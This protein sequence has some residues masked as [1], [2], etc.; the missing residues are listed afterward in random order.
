[1]NDQVQIKISAASA[2]QRFNGCDPAFIRDVCHARCCDAPSRPT[3]TLI[4]IHPSEE[5]RIRARDVVVQSG[6]LQ[7]RSGERICPFKNAD[8]LCTL[9][10]TP[11]KPFG[12]IASP[13]TLNKNDTLIIRN[14][15]RL[16]PCYNTGPRL[17]AYR[18]FSASLALILGRDGARAL[19]D[20]L[21]SGGGDILVSIP[22]RIHEMLKTNDAIK[23]RALD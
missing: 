22:A 9:H 3:G 2:R 12:C 6:L 8:H 5:S 19:T 21:D 17:P 18:A 10:Y 1:M 14:R 23:H 4:T 11:D 7:P 13:F 20:H 16:L 15:Y